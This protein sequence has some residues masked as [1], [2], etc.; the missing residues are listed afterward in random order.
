MDYISKQYIEIIASSFD[1]SLKIYIKNIKS[2]KDIE[3]KI[4]YENIDYHN[5]LV[6]K[7]NDN[8][9]SQV[10]IVL[11]L[12]S[13]EIKYFVKVIS[14][15]NRNMTDEVLDYY[16]ILFKNEKFKQLLK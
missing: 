9:Y 7:C 12:T 13:E 16:N 6:K 4:K 3:N 2:L 14:D 8:L 15:L 11:E 10:G 5:M 1:L